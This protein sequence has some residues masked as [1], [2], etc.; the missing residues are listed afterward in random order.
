MCLTVA[1]VS[2]RA[3]R[4]VAV[5]EATL[6]VAGLTSAGDILAISGVAVVGIS[7]GGVTGLGVAIIE[8]DAGIDAGG[9]APGTRW[10]DIPD[11]WVCPECGIGKADFEMMEI[12]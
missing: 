7:T 11:D 6:V 3:S 10:D 1:G 8:N 9:T 2:R 5:T 4:G 12:D